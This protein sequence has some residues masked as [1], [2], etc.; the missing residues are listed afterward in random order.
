MDFLT[1]KE[2]KGLKSDMISSKEILNSEKNYY[3]NLL[4]NK[5]GFE[6]ENYFSNKENLN[7]ENKISEKRKNKNTLFKFIMKLFSLKN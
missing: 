7:K 1:E 5:Y 4:K 6:I 3:E 2:L